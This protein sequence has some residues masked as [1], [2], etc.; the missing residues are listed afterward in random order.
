MYQ[1]WKSK[2]T[3]TQKGTEPITLCDHSGIKIPATRLT[4]HIQTA[5]CEKSTEMRIRQRDVEMV[6]R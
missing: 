1:H 3:I 5:M 6:E 4:K 2:A